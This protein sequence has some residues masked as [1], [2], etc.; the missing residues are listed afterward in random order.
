MKEDE[1]FGV[2]YETDGSSEIVN[3]L[4]ERH[5]K[6]REINELLDGS[7]KAIALVG[8]RQTLFYNGESEDNNDERNDFATEQL[9]N[10]YPG[11][12]EIIYGRVMICDIEYIH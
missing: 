1:A 12:A 6:P 3:P 4:N 11:T 10:S 5:F 7:R 2:I 9:R 8:K